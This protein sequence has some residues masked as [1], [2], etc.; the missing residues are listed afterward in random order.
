MEEVKEDSN[1]LESAKKVISIIEEY[2]TSQ[3]DD[4]MIK[5]VLKSKTG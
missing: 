5:Q 2:K 4:S 3:V 1:M